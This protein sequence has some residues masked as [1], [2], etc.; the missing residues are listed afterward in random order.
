MDIQ[1]FLL[2]SVFDSDFITRAFLPTSDSS[3]E[4]MES[5]EKLSLLDVRIDLEID[6]IAFLEDL[7]V[8]A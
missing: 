1:D 2:V 6:F 8:L 3:G 5:S 7:E 4:T